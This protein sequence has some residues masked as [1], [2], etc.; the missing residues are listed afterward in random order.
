MW[1]DCV[2]V[3]RAVERRGSRA[4]RDRGSGTG[5]VREWR[6]MG[7]RRRRKWIELSLKHLGHAQLWRGR[8]M[9]HGRRRILIIRTVHRCMLGIEVQGQRAA[10][11]GHAGRGS[12]GTGSQQCGRVVKERPEK[13]R[14]FLQ[15]LTHNGYLMGEDRHLEDEMKGCESKN[16]ITGNPI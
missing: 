5:L 3:G 12:H 11:W 13:S 4:V 9:H 16:N 7:G 15:L 2:L 8:F 14:H 10:E 6:T 1:H